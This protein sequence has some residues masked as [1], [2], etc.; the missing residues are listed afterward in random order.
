MMQKLTQLAAFCINR[1]TAGTQHPAIPTEGA[2]TLNGIVSVLM[3]YLFTLFFGLSIGPI[4]WNVCAEI[5]PL[6]I[7]ARCCAITTCTQWIFQMVVASATPLLI[8][9]TGWVT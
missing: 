2:P 1:L 9:R 3:V 5:F 7:N 6:H 4:S 8:A